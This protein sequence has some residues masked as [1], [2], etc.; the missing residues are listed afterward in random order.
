[1]TT[2]IL[3]L[4]K[5]IVRE[6]LDNEPWLRTVAKIAGRSFQE[7]RAAALEFLDTDILQ[8]SPENCVAFLE[9]MIASWDV[10]LRS[11][12]IDV[13]LNPRVSP[14]V[15]KRYRFVEQAEAEANDH[16]P[17]FAAFVR[18]RNLSGSATHEEIAFLE[19]LT[20]TARRPTALYFY[21][22]LQN[23]RDPLHFD[24]VAAR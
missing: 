16:N 2:T 21:R 1:V 24:P 3:D 7:M 9:P 11:F 4:V 6:Q 8:L 19:R 13:H 5:R 15:A 23:L 14:V 18:D 17:G 20:F 12:G 22:E 10:D